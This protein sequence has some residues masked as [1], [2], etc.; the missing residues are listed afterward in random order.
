M[1]WYARVR[2]VE[3][4][5]EVL[6]PLGELIE[7]S[8]LDAEK[9]KALFPD[10]PD[11]ALPKVCDFLDEAEPV[12]DDEG[13][14][15]FGTVTSPD[16]EAVLPFLAHLARPGSLIVV[17][18]EDELPAGWAVLEGGSLKELALGFVDPESGRHWLVK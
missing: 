1:G 5:P 9:V 8:P 13:R 11:K 12:L 18:I 7:D 16:L 6:K 15:W 10:L 4:R 3:V 2:P 17:E 14:V